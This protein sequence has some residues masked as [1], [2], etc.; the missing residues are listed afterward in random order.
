MENNF[1]LKTLSK[2]ERVNHPAH[3]WEVVK[4]ADFKA[5]KRDVPTWFAILEALR[6]YKKS[7]RLGNERN[8]DLHHSLFMN[9]VGRYANEDAIINNDYLSTTYIPRRGGRGAA[10]MH[11]QIA[12]GTIREDGKIYLASLCGGKGE[13]VSPD[14][15]AKRRPIDTLKSKWN[16]AT[17]DVNIIRADALYDGT[18]DTIIKEV[19]E[20]LGCRFPRAIKSQ[21]SI[22]AYQPRS[23]A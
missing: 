14:V 7:V 9:L 20:E 12:D 17:R 6:R 5:L 10:N 21:L 19:E 1:L 18:A 13:Y 4:S 8:A 23:V 16:K 2:I 15:W 11:G 3:I 22:K